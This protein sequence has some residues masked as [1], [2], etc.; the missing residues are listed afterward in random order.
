MVLVTVC[1]ISGPAKAAESQSAPDSTAITPWVPQA[2]TLDIFMGVDFNYRDI[3]LYNDRVFDLLIN[4]TPGVKWYLG[5][6]WEIAAQAKIPVVNQYG[7]HYKN[8][9]LSMAAVSKQF[10]IA[11]RWK[12]KVSAGLFDMERYGI[13]WKNM[14][15]INRWLAFTLQTGITGHCFLGNGWEMSKMKR[16]SALAGPEVYLRQWDTQLS[17]RGGR[18]IFG[19]YGV[20][21]EGFRHFRHVSVG[22]Y[23][24]YSNKGK[25]NAGFK[26]VVM[27]PPYKRKHRTVNFRPASNFRVTYSTEAESYAN[28]TYF[29]D[30]EQNERDGW[31]TRDL[32]PWGIDEKQ[33]DFTTVTDRPD[34]SKDKEDKK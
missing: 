3:W 12:S 33:P 11:G 23:A 19:D 1:L 26:V 20:E 13:D 14:V 16:I 9:R 2:G 30:P 15:I 22:A 10:A 17:L 5:H 4:L 8:I 18:Y 25:D 21:L 28:A 32:L 7:D 29:T 27:L 31:F 6:R 24:C 34:N